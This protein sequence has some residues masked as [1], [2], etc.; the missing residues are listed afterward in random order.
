MLTASY[1]ISTVSN[2]PSTLPW[3]PRKR[4]RS[5]F[6]TCQFLENRTAALPPEKPT[7]T[8]Q[9]LAYDLHHPQSVKHGI[10]KCL[11][12]RAKRLMTKPSVISEEKILPSV[13]V[14]NGYPSS[15]MQM[16]TRTRIAAP[17]VE[18]ETE[19]KSTMVLP[20]IKGVSEPLRHCLQQ[21]GTFAVFKS[22]TTFS[23]TKAHR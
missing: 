7:H 23:A 3:K 2:P 8:D 10:V 9:Y 4:V 16:L 14:S 17:R 6:S 15:F 18:P 11:H 20:Y 19:F 21:Q 22:D 5:P 13:L 1:N 12:D